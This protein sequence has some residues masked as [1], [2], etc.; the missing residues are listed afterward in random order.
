MLEQFD[1]GSCSLTSFLDSSE[2]VVSRR[3]GWRKV[4]QRE[5]CEV[6][7]Q[8]FSSR[9]SEPQNTKS[10]P[11]VLIPTVPHGIPT[12][13]EHVRCF[14]ITIPGRMASYPIVFFY[15]GDVRSR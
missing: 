5:V 8:P 12:P 10:I 6:S 14:N 15:A 1:S 9:S 11:G 2:N 13:Q 7:G 3:S 4:I